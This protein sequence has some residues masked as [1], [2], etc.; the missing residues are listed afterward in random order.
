VAGCTM[1][2]STGKAMMADANHPSSTPLTVCANAC[3]MTPALALGRP[4]AAATALAAACDWPCK[5]AAAMSAFGTGTCTQRAKNIE[6]LGINRRESAACSPCI[7]CTSVLAAKNTR[8]SL[9]QLHLP[10]QH[11]PEQQ[12][13][14]AQTQCL[15][16]HCL[17]RLEQLRHQLPVCHQRLGLPQR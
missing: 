2:Y 6:L 16:R 12:H 4:T 1:H 8:Q 5:T 11:L 15:W 3:M 14:S 9:H 13:W 10:Q 17:Q 7:H